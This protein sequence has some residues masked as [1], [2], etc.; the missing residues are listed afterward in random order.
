MVVS[1][2]A[3]RWHIHTHGLALVNET[4]VKQLKPASLRLCF[5]FA[6]KQRENTTMDRGAG[7]EE[8]GG[9]GPEQEGRGLRKWGLRMR[10]RG[11][12]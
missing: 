7:L 2:T 3:G 1:F 11:G 12:A 4:M 10:G 9:E 6:S 8:W 5:L